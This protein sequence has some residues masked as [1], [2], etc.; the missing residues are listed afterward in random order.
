MSI[1]N[2]LASYFRETSF[3]KWNHINCL[4]YLAKVQL[5]SISSYSWMLQKANNKAIKM[6]NVPRIHSSVKTLPRFLNDWI[7]SPIVSSTELANKRKYSEEESPFKIPLPRSLNKDALLTTFGNL[8]FDWIESHSPASKLTKSYTNSEVSGP[9]SPSSYDHAVGDTRKSLHT[10]ILNLITIIFENAS[11]VK[12]YSLQVIEYRM[13]LYSLNMLNDDFYGFQEEI[14][15]KI[16]IM[17]DL[18]L[19]ID[20][21]EGNKVRDVLKIPK[22][23]KNIPPKYAK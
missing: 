14:T 9:P 17:K 11:E 1:P 7:Y 6:P 18:D 2:E 16:L 20:H 19:T 8:C 23:L 13:T 15:K 5:R 22:S 4:E 3:D 21:N 10:D 12:V